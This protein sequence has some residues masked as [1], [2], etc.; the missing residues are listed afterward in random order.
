MIRMEYDG[1]EL[2]EFVCAPS[3]AALLS[4]MSI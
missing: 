2:T 3:R 1:D 4:G